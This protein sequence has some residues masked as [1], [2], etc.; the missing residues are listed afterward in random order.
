MEG[1]GA[2]IPYD[3]EKLSCY[4]SAQVQAVPDDQF[5]A[6]LG[7]PIPQDKWDRSAPLDFNDSLSQMI[8][9]KGF[10]ARFA[11]G[12]LAAMQRKSE[13][14]GEPNL[15]VLF[16]HNMPFRALAK[17]SNGMATTEMSY[18]ILDACNGHFFRGVGKAIGGFFANGKV[19]KERS[20]KL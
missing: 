13:A 16:I 3:R 12:R 1:T 5:E 8:Y 20:K 14:K 2:P 15:N 19:K 10:V 18:A 7:R 6:L 17:M 11:A 4:Y 9:A